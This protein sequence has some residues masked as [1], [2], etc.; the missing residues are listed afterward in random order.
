MISQADYLAHD[1]TGLSELVRRGDVSAAELLS[2]AIIRA[3]AVNP[4]LN[5]IVTPFH[6]LAQKRAAGPLTGPLAGVPFLLKD[7]F[8]HYAGVPSSAGNVALKQRRWTPDVHAEIVRRWLAGGLVPFGMT[9]TPEFGAKG[10]TEPDAWGPSRNPWHSAHTP[11]GSSGGSAAAVASGIVPAAGANDG[12]G[13]IRIPAAYTGL[14]GLKPGR[15]RTPNGPQRGE[16]MHG[17]AMQHVLTRTVRDSATLLDLTHGAEPAS[18]YKLA[19]PERPYLEEVTREPGRLRIAFSVQSPLGLDVDPEA[20]TAVEQAARLLE[21]LGH[22]VEVAAPQLDGRKLLF[23]FLHVWYAHAA[24]NVAETRAL[25]GCAATEFEL[26]TLALAAMGRSLS[27]LDYVESYVRWSEY[28]RALGE[29]HQQYDLFVT[30]TVAYPAPRVGEVKTPAWLTALMRQ[31]FKVGLDRAIALAGDAVDKVAV[32]S[33]RRVPFTQLA[34]LTGV[35]AMSVPLHVTADGLPLG[36]QFVAAHGG[37]GLLFS[38]AGQLERA[39]PWSV[40]ARSG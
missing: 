25:V 10:I 39:A 20:V 33:L 31:G 11:G 2:A 15:G 18:W 29:F 35:P 3:E 36:V 32:D 17:A 9:N 26:D 12:G 38:V 24:A 13:S 30:P 19:P 6:E 27:A 23:D 16:L 34:N 37:E 8:Q 21:S 4:R 40:V 7:L 22:S 28:S 5:A 14:F 1:A